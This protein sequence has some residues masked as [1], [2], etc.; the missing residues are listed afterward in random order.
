MKNQHLSREV[1]ISHHE[2]LIYDPSKSNSHGSSSFMEER[3]RVT[4][5]EITTM[6]ESVLR[7][8]YQENFIRNKMAL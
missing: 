7:G 4:I 6:N 5:N 8:I 1:L 3:R 2:G